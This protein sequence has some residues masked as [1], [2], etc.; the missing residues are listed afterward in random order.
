M[1]TLAGGRFEA[2]T[3]SNLYVAAHGMR[4]L[5]VHM[6]QQLL[7]AHGDLVEVGAHACCLLGPSSSPFNVGSWAVPGSLTNRQAQLLAGWDQSLG[8]YNC[9]AFAPCFLV[10]VS[11]RVRELDRDPAPPRSPSSLCLCLYACALPALMAWDPLLL[12]H[13]TA[14]H[15]SPL[16]ALATPVSGSVCTG[17]LCSHKTA[18]GVCVTQARAEIAGFGAI[19]LR[20]RCTNRPTASSF[21][22]TSRACLD[23]LQLPRARC[24]AIPEAAPW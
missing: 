12:P 17:R 9:Y 22:A 13:Q 6:E 19:T 24:G 20:A 15:S 3:G 16:L 1:G 21:P 10:H 23:F 14:T 5:A 4:M 11:S 18:G 7:R 2:L 8:F